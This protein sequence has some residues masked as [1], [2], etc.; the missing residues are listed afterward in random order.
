MLTAALAGFCIAALNPESS[1]VSTPSALGFVPLAGESGFV[2]LRGDLSCV[3]RS[4][5]IEFRG[6]AHGDR[7]EIRM[8]RSGRPIAVERLPG[9]VNFFLGSDPAR[10]RTEVPHFAR[11]RLSDVAPG[12]DLE[13]FA[14]ADGFEY[15]VIAATPDAL[16]ACEFEWRGGRV[17]DSAL[18]VIAVDATDGA[19][20]HR[21][22]EVFVSDEFGRRSPVAARLV[23]CGDSRFRFEVAAA[24]YAP[25]IVDPGI[26]F[27]TYLGST[28][29]DE[30][31]DVAVDATGATILCGTCGAGDF[32]VVAGSFDTTFGGTF[33]DAFVV[34]LNPSGTLAWA[35]F[36][37]GSGVDAA[38]SLA[39]GSDGRVHVAGRTQST[40][41]P[42]AGLGY[43][44]TYNGAI[45]GFI[46]ALAPDGKSLV[47]STYLG[48]GADDEI[49]AIAVGTGNVVHVAGYTGSLDFPATVSSFDP[50]FN[51]AGPALTDAFV[52]RFLGGVS[53]LSYATFLGGAQ[54]DVANALAVVA[55]EAVIAGRTESPD[56]PIVAG[57]HDLTYG[58]G[59]GDGFL[60][61]LDANGAVLLRSSYIGGTDRDSLDALAAHSDGSIFTAGY[62]RSV[63]LGIPAGFD[64][65]HGGNEDGF[66][67]VFTPAHVAA[68]GN[69]HGGSNDDRATGVAVDPTGASYVAGRTNSGDFPVLQSSFDPSWNGST[70][71]F[72][73]KVRA[74][75]QGLNE[76]GYLGGSGFDEARAIA[77][78]PNGV[79]RLVG[80]TA[81]SNFPN[82]GATQ[83]SLKGSSD[84]FVASL[85]TAICSTPP[86]SAVF[87]AGK[88]GTF[89]VPVFTATGLPA[90]PSSTMVLSVSNALPGAAPLLFL[91]FQPGAIPF[92][93]GTILVQ[94][95]L[96]LALPPFNALGR[97]D[98]PTAFGEDA[99]LCGL[100]IYLQV[101]FGDPGAIGFYHTAQTNGVQLVFGS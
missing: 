4:D 95:A 93:K 48:G 97:L 10:H 81:S 38:A 5:A 69:F 14:T 52:A 75:G 101:V 71:A 70:D 45:D 74:A 42:F 25:V 35:T 100:S 92:D 19:F 40:N 98:L 96:I 67:F 89:G 47:H 88:P 73:A 99:G 13:V 9:S 24:T 82:P 87:G 76:T 83:P 7:F 37:G 59:L 57:A 64:L 15:D 32:P 11:I 58:G 21:S 22:S 34:K 30:A 26:Q 62:T 28:L 20:L 78:G 50:T 77:V 53:T 65:L 33:S 44:A 94:P 8:P 49:L 85:P 60:A 63:D 29:F 18:G 80:R 31:T 56:F 17:R 66:L 27:A 86:V 79:A 36:L 16:A 12:V 2:A 72:F 91:G 41:F 6:R 43:D 23:E 68:W 54:I 39:L 84:A 90:V 46:A 51:G 55:G 3:V 61:R 1:L